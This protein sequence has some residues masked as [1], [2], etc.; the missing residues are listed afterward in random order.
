MHDH[1]FYSLSRK[2]SNEM[3]TSF[4][5]LKKGREIIQLANRSCSYLKLVFI[6]LKP[7]RRVFISLSN[8]VI[9]NNK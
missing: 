9:L 1:S 8:K 6:S 3:A 2:H 5:Q 7:F 4:M